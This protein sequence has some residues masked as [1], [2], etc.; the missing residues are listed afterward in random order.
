MPDILMIGVES[1]LVKKSVI[2]SAGFGLCLNTG[3]NSFEERLIWG[4]F[5]ISSIIQSEQEKYGPAK[6]KPMIEHNISNFKFAE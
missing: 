1:Y 3:K 2:L 6:S 4:K 5:L